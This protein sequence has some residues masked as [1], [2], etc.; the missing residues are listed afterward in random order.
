M[1]EGYPI[2]RDGAVLHA[3]HLHA[4]TLFTLAEAGHALRGRWGFFRPAGLAAGQGVNEI[5]VEDGLVVIK[6]L[7]LRTPDGFV[8]RAQKLC[9]KDRAKV[10]EV[11]RLA[12]RLP[13]PSSREAS[14]V[15]AEM[16]VVPRGAGPGGR[17][18]VEIGSVVEVGSV[19]VEEASATLGVSLTAPVFG[20]GGAEELAR[21]WRDLIE[22][23][24]VLLRLAE[25]TERSRHGRAFERRVV[26]AAFRRV[27]AMPL[28]CDTKQAMWELESAFRQLADFAWA[29]A[30]A[31]EAV[32]VETAR[33]LE[34]S[35]KCR[36]RAEKLTPLCGGLREIAAALGERA[37]T[38]EWLRT[39]R[40]RLDPTG[41]LDEGGQLRVLHYS[42][43]DNIDTLDIVPRGVHPKRAMAWAGFD[44]AQL[45]ELKDGQIE[46]GAKWVVKVPRSAS[47][48]MLR[49]QSH[50]TVEVHGLRGATSGD[51]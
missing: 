7:A 30:R 21:T 24:G 22:E 27:A 19:A 11:V 38:W 44:G 16:S 49:C 29:Y 50:V 15:R 45:D 32:V 40:R 35:G 4:Q 3:S 20:L 48:F 17:G 6:N 18:S 14:V 31:G 5:G 12:W 33:V 46:D 9:A 51:G 26:S 28:D 25:K 13:E 2:P 43:D 36:E 1:S 34:A 47:R 23:D 37:S 8:V 39:E 42:V 41:V 10:D